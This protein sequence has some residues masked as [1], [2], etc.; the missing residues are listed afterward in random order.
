MLS[1]TSWF[2]AR[3]S[4]GAHRMKEPPKLEATVLLQRL[5]AGEREVESE[6]Y[7]L[8]HAELHERAHRLMRHQPAG[9]TLQ[10]TA[11]VHEAWMKLAPA[12]KDIASSRA[13]FCKLAAR[14]MRSV[15]VDHARA[16][17]TDKR[18]GGAQQLPL[19][20]RDALTEGPNSTMLALDDA[21]TKLQAVDAELVRVAE[22]RLFAGLEH[23]EIAQVLGVSS[24]TVE[25]AWKMARAWLQ[26]EMA[27]DEPE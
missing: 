10:T 4:P 12:D 16:G 9:H 26:R 27:G 25:R 20:E 6:L 1:S 24:R 2:A 5:A 21:L 13:H 23:S 7:R 17:A 11:L 8:L 3:E 15:L 22:L 14:A 18:G 19:D